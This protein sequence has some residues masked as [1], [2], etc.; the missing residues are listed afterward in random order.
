MRS[1]NC[2]ISSSSVPSICIWRSRSLHVLVEQ[3]SVHQRLLDGAAQIVEG[4]LALQ[5]VVKHVVLEAALQQ[6]IGERAEQVFHAHLAGGV[7][8]VLAVADAF[9]KKQSSVVG[10]QSFSEPNR[11][12]STTDDRR[13]T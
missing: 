10:L 1:I 7:G 5:H 2:S 8:N 13:L 4:L 9:H 6:V 11:L 3:I 12:G